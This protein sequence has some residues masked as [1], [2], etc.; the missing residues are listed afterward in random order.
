MIGII[1]HSDTCASWF[2]KSPTPWLC[3]EELVEANIREIRIIGFMWAVG[4]TFLSQ[5]ASNTDSVPMTL[6]HHDVSNQRPW[7]GVIRD[8]ATVS[9]NV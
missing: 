1:G 4:T 6:H 5:K 2:T 3:A 7:Q 8:D 9:Y